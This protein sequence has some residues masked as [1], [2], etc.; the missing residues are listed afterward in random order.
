MACY[1]GTTVD[2]NCSW[3]SLFGHV[4]ARYQPIKPPNRNKEKKIVDLYPYFFALFVPRCP[5]APFPCRA[6]N[7]AGEAVALLVVVGAASPRAAVKVAA[8]TEMDGR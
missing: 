5:L 3:R 6:P 2:L 7:T 4:K 8:I 1:H